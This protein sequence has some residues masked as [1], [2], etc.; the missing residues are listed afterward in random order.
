LTKPPLSDL[1]IFRVKFDQDC[2]ALEAV[3][4]QAGRSSAAE[5]IQNRA[6]CWASGENAWLDERWRERRE[7]GF[8][9]R[10]RRHFPHGAAI[11]R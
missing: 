4:D 2:V 6:A 5:R 3:S 8:A 10:L 11:A 9:E 1:S 7:M